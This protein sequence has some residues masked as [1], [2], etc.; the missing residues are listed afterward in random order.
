MSVISSLSLLK[1]PSSF[2]VPPPNEGRLGRER[3]GLGSLRSCRQ[4]T[5]GHSPLRPDHSP[6]M[7][8]GFF[9]SNSWGGRRCVY[10]RRVELGRVG[11]VRAT[12]LYTLAGP[13]AAAERGLR[14]MPR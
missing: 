7:S 3:E 9:G 2:P 5:L 11:Y 12:G 13:R 6:P 8:A 1:M 4:L 14:Y 10:T